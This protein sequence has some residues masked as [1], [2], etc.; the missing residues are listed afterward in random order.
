[1][2]LLTMAKALNLALREA[3]ASDDRT[4]I[5]GED[6][7]QDEGVFRIT[8]GLL[9]E[10]G[11]DRVVDFPLAESAIVGLAVGLCFTGFRPICEMQ[12]DGFSYHAYH[13]VEN[14][15]SRYRNR[16]RGR[17]TCP[18]VIRIPYGGGHPGNRAS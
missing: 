2:A 15:I 14:H 9:K 7:G 18:M 17:Y 3:L 13:Q 4:M 1:M 5:I 11:P 12:F 6:V 10:F 16:T 8:E